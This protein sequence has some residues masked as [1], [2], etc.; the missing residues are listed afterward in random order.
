MHPCVEGYKVAELGAIYGGVKQRWLVVFSEK[1]KTQAIRTL[2]THI[3]KE[4][5]QAKKELKKLQATEYSCS[6]D[7]ERALRSWEEK[8][9]YHK[10]GSVQ[11]RHQVKRTGRGRPK[12]TDSE[13]VSYRLECEVERDEAKITHAEEGKGLF[14]IATN[15]LDSD[16]LP[17]EQL[18]SV[19]KDGQQ[20]VERGFRLLKD[21]RFMTSS[22]FLKK[23]QRII[24]LG[25]VM[26]LSLLIYTLTQ[27]KLRLELQK[28]KITI[29]SQTGKPIKKLT[30]RWQCAGSTNA[31]KELLF[32]M[33]KRGRRGVNLY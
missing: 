15:E 29:P 27:R 21:P 5:A 13:V 31:L 18:L 3:T 7:A 25:L 33:R 23:E 1:R 26:C 20:S 2:Q 6:K 16:A 10:C 22:V 30:M 11:M 9:K 4:A 28:Q 24:A 8:L 14:I 17:A 12:I 19:Y 32:F